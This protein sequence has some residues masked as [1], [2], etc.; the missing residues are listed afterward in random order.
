MCADVSLPSD[1]TEFFTR[2]RRYIEFLAY[3]HGVAAQDRDDVVSTIMMRLF[4]KDFLSLYDDTYQGWNGKSVKFE[5]FL[6]ATVIS[7]IRGLKWHAVSDQ[8]GR[9]EILLCD[10]SLMSPGDSS[11]TSWIS[12]Q[13]DSRDQFAECDERL[14]E[15]DLV[16]RL[17]ENLRQLAHPAV[18][19]DLV[20]LFDAV[21]SQVRQHGSYSTQ[22]LSEDFSVSASSIRSWVA[23]IKSNL[24][25]VLRDLQQRGL[26]L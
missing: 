25:P 16:D 9:R 22:Q 13:P 15:Q 23:W 4:K 8:R 2:Y 24:E 18:K 12:V 20:D 3:N 26:A 7:H 19:I 10:C 11:G 5:T 14:V 6:T 21:V 1:Y 17:R